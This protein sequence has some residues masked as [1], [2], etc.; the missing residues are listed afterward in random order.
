MKKLSLTISAFCLAL[1][2]TFGQQQQQQPDTNKHS[3][4]AI[5]GFNAGLLFSGFNYDSQKFWGDF[6][7]A[8]SENKY[9]T[10]F[11]AGLSVSFINSKHFSIQPEI[12]YQLI[13]HDVK[14]TDIDEQ[15]LYY[16]SVNADY[17]LTSSNI[18]LSVLFKFRTGDKV[19]TYIGLGPYVNFPI[20]N[21]IKGTI[22]TKGHDTIAPQFDSILTDNEIKVKIK[23]SFGCYLVTGLNI[24]YKNNNFG[25]EF[26]FYFSPGILIEYPVTRQSFFT[27]S[28]TY[29]FKSNKNTW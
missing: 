21:G 5:V 10:G 24:P 19:K 28:L 26:R 7:Y 27:I 3:Q 6:P 4:I 14:Y 23:N 15:F 25:L 20:Y 2:S 12:F 18:Q 11:S 9:R 13:H 22:E 17:S 8:I 29:Q 1:L 16:R